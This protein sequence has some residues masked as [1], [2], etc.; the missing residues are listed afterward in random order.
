MKL[1]YRG[2]AYSASAPVLEV[3]D[4]ELSGK[5]R[6]VPLKFSTQL[7]PCVPNSMV[8]LSYRGVDYLGMR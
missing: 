7:K 6:G 2:I 5:Y 4:C 8:R 1:S 3:S